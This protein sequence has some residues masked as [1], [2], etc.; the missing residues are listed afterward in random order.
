MNYYENSVILTD[1]LT[2]EETR[3][4]IERIKSVMQENGAQVLKVDEWGIRKLAFELEKR[5]KGF[6]AFFLL[7]A[8]ATTIKKLEEFYKIFDPVMKFMV[9]K[10]EKAQIKV[11]EEALAAAPAAA[12]EAT[13]AAAA[14]SEEAKA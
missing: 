5:K 9:I 13:P 14:S 7:K 8:P 2:E 3:S 12:P 11:V 10:L 4:A 6:Y 1:K